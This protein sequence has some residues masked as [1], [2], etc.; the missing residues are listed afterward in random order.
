VEEIKELGLTVFAH[1]VTPTAGEPKG[2]GELEVP[3][4]CGGAEVE[5]GDFIVA[6]ENGVVVIP[7]KRVVEVANKAAYVREKEDR[8]KKEIED[9]KTIGQ[10]LELGKWDKVG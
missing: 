8:V 3:I 10:I 6:D 2:M 9:G 5:T 4:R 1:Y 7:K